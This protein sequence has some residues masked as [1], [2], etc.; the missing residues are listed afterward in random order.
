[1]SSV[2]NELDVLYLGADPH[3]SLLHIE[4]A[5]HKSA[6]PVSRM[7]LKVCGGKPTCI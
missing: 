5:S 2:V 7:T 1:M 6:E 4:D 3:V